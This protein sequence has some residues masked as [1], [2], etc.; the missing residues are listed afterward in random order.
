MEELMPHVMAQIPPEIR[1]AGLS[2]EQL[3]ASV[4]VEQRLAGLTPEQL[5]LLRAEEVVKVMGREW[6]VL[7]LPNDLLE[8]Q[9]DEVLNSLSP[10]ARERVR[11]RIGR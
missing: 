8:M 2:P 10:G 3:V 7:A 4:P 6:A 9:P 5:A 11:Q 1:L